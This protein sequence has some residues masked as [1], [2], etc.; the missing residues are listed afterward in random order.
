[1]GQRSLERP[2]LIARLLSESLRDLVPLG[3][4]FPTSGTSFKGP[5]ALTFQGISTVTPTDGESCL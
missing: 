3:L 5:L 4:S 1:M 2:R